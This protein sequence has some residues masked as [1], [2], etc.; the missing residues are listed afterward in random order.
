M[1]LSNKIFERFLFLTFS[2]EDFY[3]MDSI[4]FF[5]PDFDWFVYRLSLENYFKDANIVEDY[6]KCAFL[7]TVLDSATLEILSEIFWPDSLDCKTYDEICEVMNDHFSLEVTIRRSREA[8]I[9]VSRTD[10]ESIQDWYVRLKKVWE[11]CRF[12]ANLEKF[13]LVKF[14]CGLTGRSFESIQLN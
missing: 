3:K 10:D 1:K 14:I 11:Q 6:R 9:E 13:L 5:E 12:G 4:T 8:F 7:L 2:I